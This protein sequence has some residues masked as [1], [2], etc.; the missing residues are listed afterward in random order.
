M[1]QKFGIN[2]VVNRIK[3]LISHNCRHTNGSSYAKSKSSAKSVNNLHFETQ[4][5]YIHYNNF[6]L[7]YITLIV[8][9]LNLFQ[10]SVSIHS[11][12]LLK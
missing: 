8:M 1:Q 9:E 11:K 7:G 4:Q 2:F 6:Y 5:N 3:L 10:T 12:I